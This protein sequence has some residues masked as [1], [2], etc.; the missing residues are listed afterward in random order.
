MESLPSLSFNSS[1][2]HRILLRFHLNFI[3][4]QPSKPLLKFEPLTQART[5]NPHTHK[6]SKLSSNCSWRFISDSFQWYMQEP[7]EANKQF[8]SIWNTPKEFTDGNKKQTLSYF[9]Y[10]FSVPP[11]IFHFYMWTSIWNKVWNIWDC[12]LHLHSYCKND[13]ILV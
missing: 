13:K 7:C 12:S 3:E 11:H 8:F 4:S 5:Y 6:I 9:S 1:C 10:R 2:S